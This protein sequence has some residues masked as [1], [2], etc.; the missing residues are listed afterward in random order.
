MGCGRSTLRQEMRNADNIPSAT[1][2]AQPAAA[3][4]LENAAPQNA[5]PAR[6]ADQEEQRS[7]KPLVMAVPFELDTGAPPEHHPRKRA[8]LGRPLPP[9][10]QVSPLLEA[11][12][13]AIVSQSS[14]ASS[15]PANLVVFGSL[16]EVS[17]QGTLSSMADTESPLQRPL[18]F[19][20]R[21]KPRLSYSGWFPPSP[22][23][24]L[25][26][27]LARVAFDDEDDDD[28][29]NDKGDP[30]ATLEML[31]VGKEATYREIRPKE[32]A[33]M[34]GS[35]TSEDRTPARYHAR[36]LADVGGRLDARRGAGANGVRYS[37][38]RNA[39][40][41]VATAVV[42]HSE[43]ASCDLV[44]FDGQGRDGALSRRGSAAGEDDEQSYGDKQSLWATL[45]ELGDAA[46]EQ[47]R[48]V[49]RS[50]VSVGNGEDEPAPEV[51]H[52]G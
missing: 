3:V 35:V 46:W 37:V 15:S 26:P 14:R 32:V 40:A 31:T 2:E 28:G 4:E 50:D 6:P 39:K 44:T 1:V 30:G 10:L 19:A 45:D 49:F 9:P 41:A 7:P 27:S 23:A 22:L 12:A 18:W 51:L 38:A 13:A 20:P 24:P 33:W 25:P 34:S 43:S 52:L 48:E 21:W 5:S 16:D 11:A 42:V 8:L 29:D 36:A 17:H 47:S